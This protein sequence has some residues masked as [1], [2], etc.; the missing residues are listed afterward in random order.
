VIQLFIRQFE[1]TGGTFS[2]EAH[3]VLANDDHVVDLLTVRGERD[4]KHLAEKVVLTA[5]VTDGKFAEVWVHAT[6]LYALDE[7]FA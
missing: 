6:D 1:L 7:F 4:G 5:H 3:D 2:V